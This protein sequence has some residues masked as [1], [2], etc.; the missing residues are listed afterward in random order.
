MNARRII[1]I[2]LCLTL[3]FA[4]YP[5]AAPAE[6]VPA[7]PQI[8]SPANGI[9][10]VN[11]K[12][13]YTGTSDPGTTVSVKVN[14]A[15]VGSA[16]VDASGNWSITHSSPLSDGS[17][18]VYAVASDGAG[19]TS[20]PSNAITFTVDT[21]AP[22]APEVITPEHGSAT[23]DDTP[24]ITGTAEAGSTI[25]IYV[26]SS[27]VGATAASGSG[28]WSFT[29]TAALSDGDHTVEATAQDAAGNISFFS[30]SNQFTVDTVPPGA[31]SVIT[32]EDGSRTADS[33]PA[34]SGQA[35]NSNTVTVIVDGAA[36]E[37]V[38]PDGQGNWSFTPDFALADG[39]H[40]VKAI[41]TDMAGNTSV[42]SNTNTFTV[43]ATPPDAP[44]VI[45][46]ANGSSTRF[47]TP[48]LSGTAESNSTVT[49]IVDGIVLGTTIA[50]GSGNWSFVQPSQLTEGSHTVRATAADAVGNTS[51]DSNTN[52]FTVDITPPAAP[53]VSTPAN[54]SGTNDNTPAYLGTAEANSTVTVFSDGTAQGTTT[55][56]G[57][58]NWSFT[59]LTPLTDGPHS[60][61]AT[62]ADAAGNTSVDSNTNSFTVDTTPP[63]PPVVNSPPNGYSTN[64]STPSYLGTAVAGNAV[65]IYVDGA[66]VGTVTA[67]ENGIWFLIQPTPLADGSHTVKATT[68]DAFGNTSQ[69]S[70]VNT[71]TVDIIPPAKPSIVPS[72]GIQAYI[73]QPQFYGSAEVNSTVTIY[74][75]ND[76]VGTTIARG[77]WNFTIPTPLSDGAHTIYVTARD[78]A[79]NYSSYSNIITFTV[80]TVPPAAPVITAPASGSTT[81]DSTPDI[82]GTAEALSTILLYRNGGYAGTVTADGSGN[83]SFTPASP[84]KDA[85]HTVKA[86]ARDAAGWDSV[87]STECAFT[88]DTS[89]PVSIA[90]IM[91]VT[92]PVKGAAP[93][94]HITETNEYT[95]IVAW[96]PDDAAFKPGTVYTATVTLS[97]KA[98]FRFRD[99]TANFF[100]VNGAAA[101]NEAGAGVV[102][103]VFPATLAFVNAQLS[104]AAFTH[105]LYAPAGAAAQIIFNDAQSVTGMVLGSKS[106]SSP[107]D[108]TVSGNTLT[109]QKSFLAGLG[110]KKDDSLSFQI[111]FDAGAEAVL[112]MTVVNSAP[113]MY[114]VTFYDRNE[115]HAVKTVQAGLSLGS[116]LWPVNPR[117]SGHTFGGWYTGQNGTGIAFTA[118]TSVNSEVNVYAKWSVSAPDLSQE[119]GEQTPQPQVLLNG[120]TTNMVTVGPDPNG[121]VAQILTV[122]TGG[123]GS[124]MQP[125]FQLS[126]MS[127][128]QPPPAPVYMPPTIVQSLYSNALPSLPA[129]PSANQAGFS[130]IAAMTFPGGLISDAGGGLGTLTYQTDIGST[131]MPSN[132]LSPGGAQGIPAGTDATITILSGGI[133]AGPGSMSAPFQNLQVTNFGLSMGGV[134]VLQS[135][136]A[137]QMLM[138]IPYTL[139]GPAVANPQNLA[140]MHID[141]TGATSIIPGSRYNRETGT[142]DFTTTLF[143]CFVILYQP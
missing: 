47:S 64:Y 78:A 116:T 9:F 122:G 70:N 42:D 112:S 16:T 120:G 10:T 140:V 17:Y 79:G 59:Q 130:S 1:S 138:S 21:T 97:A 103:T 34:I 38:T 127:F 111:L 94:T 2:F 107:A 74:V 48:A 108:Y 22:A 139:T 123:L 67:N 56:D 105:D 54:G 5:A 43:D 128:S 125:G 14:E 101:T 83:W 49:V 118:N 76:D 13:T 75:D 119:D 7:A 29:L 89:L 110:L 4:L 129:P 113:A 45:T 32:P 31:P 104:P 143:G 36:V 126:V 37:T 53:A 26:D 44:V 95:G 65:K 136:P 106:L 93:V 135:N 60:V 40:S 63:A 134:P 115:T 114:N 27:V 15:D 20:S 100:T 18:T 71:F 131:S 82:K 142:M 90:A 57:A 24:D 23:N 88:V 19:Y 55:A 87:F 102:K 77:T 66:V 121:L 28:N 141:E 68:A 51:V 96:S 98:G 30:D 99:V 25:T 50:D 137:A 3:L 6:M 72:F 11:N 39:S 84:L 81:N 33:T 80:D 91:G 109:I 86:K 12:P 35:G 132:L 85:N 61:K 46:P 52:N 58:G 8:I 117:W 133:G 69:D 62:A 41:A 73:P 92:P 124:L